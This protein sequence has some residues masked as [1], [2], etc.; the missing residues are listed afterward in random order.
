[1]KTSQVLKSPVVRNKSDKERERGGT[2][3]GTPRNP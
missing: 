2:L 3:E 1:M